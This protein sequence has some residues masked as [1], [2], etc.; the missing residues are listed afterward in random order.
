M[1][2]A[3]LA[4][5]AQQ[6]GRLVDRRADQVV[7]GILRQPVGQQVVADAGQR[8]KALDVAD[9]AA[10]APRN[11]LT[12]AEQ[13]LHRDVHVAQFAGHS[14]RATDNLTGFDHAAAETSAHDRRDRRAPQGELAEVCVMGVERG[15]VA[16]VAVHHGKA[17]PGFECR[18]HIEA[19]PLGQG[20]VR[21]AA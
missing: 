2:I 10:V 4:E 21:R 6:L 8:G 5:G 11:R 14:G 9:E 13:P 7:V 16:V 20:E 17:E 12:F 1:A 19:P 3:E 18:A 15:S